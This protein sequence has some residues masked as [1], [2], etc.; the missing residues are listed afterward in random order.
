VN[1]FEVLVEGT[2]MAPADG[3]RL[4]WIDPLHGIARLVGA[5]RSIAV[6][7]EGA[8]SD[9]VVTLGGRRIPVTVRSWRERILAAA[10]TEARAHGGPVEVR[11]SLPGLIVAVAVA[12]GDVVA[13]GAS[14]LTIEAMKMQNE[15]RAPRAGRVLEVQVA[16]GETVAAGAPL[17]RLG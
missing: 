3:W 12:E 5:G 6:L 8:D 11:A 1:D 13:D 2:V 17:V 7:V 10:E 16:M 15:V 9:W 4:E 14:L